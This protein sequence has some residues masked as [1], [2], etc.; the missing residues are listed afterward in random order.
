[1]RAGWVGL[2]RCVAWGGIGLSLYAGWL[3]VEDVRD[4]SA[5]ER[6]IAEACDGLVSGAAV[7]DLHGGTGRA[8]PDGDRIDTRKPRSFCTV[9]QASEAGRTT[10]LFSLTVQNSDKA[11]PLNRIG[12]TPEP[13]ALLGPDGR[14]FKTDLTA[15]ADRR[16]EPRPLGDGALG[17][18]G[19]RYTTV[20]AE[21]GPGSGP[22]A[23]PLL[24]ITAAGYDGD[25]S[26]A[27]RAR[28]ARIAR[29]A[30][31]ILTQRIGCRARLPALPDGEPAPVPTVLRPARSAGGSCAWFAGYLRHSDRGPLP[32][33]ALSVPVR[34]THPLEGCLLAVSPGQVRRTAGSLP[35]DKRDYADYAEKSPWWLRTVT[36]TGSEARA[37]GY[38]TLD[39]EEAVVIKQGTA[40]QTN[41][42]WWA[43]SVCGGKPALHTLGTSYEY[44]DA[45]GSRTVSA[46]FRA[47]VDDITERRGCTQVTFPQ[48]A[49]SGD[50]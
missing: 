20:R 2:W 37:T 26:K 3:T 4:R 23:P 33:R 10:M 17:W 5:S 39:G 32:D 25:V 31:E 50:R 35:E 19:N 43:S 28:L 44:D 40:G 21:C 34:D 38:E 7:M 18:Y 9:Y 46:L 12:P 11:E 14:T 6:A 48:A 29:S 36:Y 16:P 27:D 13:F 41:N 22:A 24:H 49:D 42:V 15:V 47:Y 30:A 45:L 1:M 8:E